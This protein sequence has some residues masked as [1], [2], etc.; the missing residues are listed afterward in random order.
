[1]KTPTHWIS[2]IPKSYKRHATLVDLH[3]SK[4]ISSNVDE[5]VQIIK[6]KFKSVG[7]L[8]LFMDKVIWAFEKA[9]IDDQKNYQMIMMMSLL[10]HHIFLKLKPFHFIKVTVMS[11]K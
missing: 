4:Q 7:Y 2:D 9:N 11:E 5:E 10:Y 3:Q 1:M 8:L 6:S